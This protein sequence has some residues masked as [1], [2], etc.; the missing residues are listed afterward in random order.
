M[1][2]T[3]SLLLAL[4]L[5]AA[6]AFSLTACSEKN[7]DSES[8]VSQNEEV[9]ADASSEDNET[10]AS[11]PF[12]GT[13]FGGRA[14]RVYTS[15]NEYDS[16]N[17]DKFIRGSGELNGEA[18]ND[19]VFNRNQ[20][21]ADLLNISYDYTEADYDYNN[22]SDAIE[23]Q[24]MAGADEWDVMANDIGGFAGL[25]RDGYIRNV[26]NSKILDLTKS[27]W[28]A[29]AMRDCQFIEG[30]MYLLIGD[31][32]TD[33][34]QSS[35]CL[36]VNEE[37]LNDVYGTTEYV[38]DMV[39]GGNWTLDG[40]IGVMEDTMRDTDG[41]GQMKEGDLFGF[42]CIGM[43]GSL[44]PFVIG[45]DIQFIERTDEGPQFCFNNERS[46]KT[47]EKLYELFYS[48][49]TLTDPEDFSTRGL[50]ILFSNNQSTILGYNR[51]GDLANFRDVE[52][53]M[54]VVPYPKLDETQDSYVSTMHDISEIGA[55]P[56]TLPAESVD[57]CHT[58]LEV[59]CRETGRTVI[60]EWYENGLKIKY[61]KGQDDAKMID[62]IHDTITGPFAVAYNSVLGDFLLTS[63]FCE[64]LAYNRPDFASAYKSNEKA[65][66]KQLQKAYDKFAE[67]L[68]N[69]N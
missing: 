4:L 6:S 55:I 38:N 9:L 50:Q 19:A 22:G 37:I 21:V 13:D 67:N 65:A 29:D 32:F 7:L 48:P 24:I 1:K 57:F 25:A 16:T 11:D 63:C 2:R 49:A 30:G 64:P 58:V 36:Y 3:I 10:E 15:V 27:Y 61:S 53:A 12:S 52:F 60:P 62:L 33:A 69:G 20:K 14:F 42:T 31:Y 26:Y 41:S 68:R 35:H 17:G 5:S 54:G 56:V 28:Y 66:S 43:W 40:M 18:V 44:I 8:P 46:V 23:S 51:L 39:F 59:L 34:L 47:L 45:S